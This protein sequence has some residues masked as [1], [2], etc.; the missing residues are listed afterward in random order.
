MKHNLNFTARLGAVS[1]L[2]LSLAAPALAVELNL[3]ISDVDKKAGVVED[4]AKRYSEV[5]PDVTIKLNLVGYNVIREQLAGQ[6]EAGI[7]P[8]LACL[9]I[10]RA[11]RVASMAFTQR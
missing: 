9:G 1:I 2:A 7:G 3:M 5:N 4:F 6:L 8:D 10:A 11:K